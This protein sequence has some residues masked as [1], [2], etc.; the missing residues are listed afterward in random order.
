M[1]RQK[2]QYSDMEQL[3]TAEAKQNTTQN[4]NKKLTNTTH[5]TSRDRHTI[6]AQSERTACYNAHK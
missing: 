2:V 4:K 6:T 5:K 1:V 3:Q